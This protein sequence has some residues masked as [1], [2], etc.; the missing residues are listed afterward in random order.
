MT[1]L[2]LIQISFLGYACLDHQPL[3]QALQR[4][5][6]IGTAGAG[7]TGWKVGAGG[8]GWKVGAGGQVGNM[9]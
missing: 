2:L 7:G 9:G 4:K 6:P 1:L 8:A 5:G 3:L